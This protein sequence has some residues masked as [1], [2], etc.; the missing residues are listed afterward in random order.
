MQ[1]SSTSVVIKTKDLRRR[2]DGGAL[3]HTTV[4]QIDNHQMKIFEVD[5]TTLLTVRDFV[6]SS[7]TGAAPPLS[8]GLSEVRQN[9][10]D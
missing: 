3:R 10:P 7:S 5:S 8:D 1:A 6:G 4:S 9:C 2:S